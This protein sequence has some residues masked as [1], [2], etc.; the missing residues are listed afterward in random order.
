MEQNHIEHRPIDFKVDNYKQDRNEWK[1]KPTAINVSTP[2][3][4]RCKANAFTS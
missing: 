2:A 4:D 3:N 1:V